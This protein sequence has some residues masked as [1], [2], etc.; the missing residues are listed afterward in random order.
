M[1]RLPVTTDMGDWHDVPARLRLA[2]FA[3]LVP[4]AVI[5]IGLVVGLVSPPAAALALAAGGPA[6]YLTFDKRRLWW[7]PERALA[8][9]P[10]AVGARRNVVLCLA[11][12]AVTVALLVLGI[13]RL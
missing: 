12:G 2:F 13:V 8:V 11:I 10:V 6:F 3:V 7:P 1:N 9:D 5:G 4:A